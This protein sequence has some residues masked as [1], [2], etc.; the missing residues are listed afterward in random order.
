MKRFI[1]AAVLGVVSLRATPVELSRS[2]VFEL[3]SA[4]SAL[5]PGLSPE[6][7]L[8]AA[9]DIN[10]LQADAE[11]FRMGYA[12]LLQLQQTA[13]AVKTPAA[14]AAFRDADAKFTAA[15]SARKTY[16]LTVFKLTASDVGAAHL[17]AATVATILRLLK[18]KT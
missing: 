6:S 3:H 2:Q 9:D 17:S 4:L 11:A 16:D 8:A 15:T 7:T 18:P 1:L 5:A 10:T 13:E 14:V 12:K